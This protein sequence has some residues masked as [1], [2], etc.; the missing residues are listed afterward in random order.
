MK[1]P[2]RKFLR[3]ATGAAALPAVPRS[4]M[5]QGYPSRPIHLITG[6]PVGGASDLVARLI[7]QQLSR[8]LDQTV[9]VESRPGAASNLATAMVVRAPPD[10]YTLLQMT[11][12][13]SWNVALYDNLTFDF[14]RDLAPVAGIYRSI[15]VVVVQP[16]FPTKTLRDFIAYLKANP[17]KVSMAS[18][19]SAL[20]NTFGARSLCRWR[21]STCCMCHSAAAGPL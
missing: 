1:L 5:A 21:A 8:R 16:S 19:A 11:A 17:G 15:G 3:L 9:V 6:F 2:R 18:G 7:A 13:N 10:G 20:H 4:A 12:S 14:I